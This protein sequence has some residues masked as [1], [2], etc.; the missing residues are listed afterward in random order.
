MG[1]ETPDPWKCWFLGEQLETKAMVKMQ[2]V[3]GS[4]KPRYSKTTTQQVE[5]RC[6]GLLGGWWWHG[7][8]GAGGRVDAP[9]SYGL[10]G[11]VLGESW[12]ALLVHLPLARLGLSVLLSIS[13]WALSSVV[14]NGSN[15][16]M[17]I[18][19][20]EGKFHT[21]T[22]LTG[23][24]FFLC[25]LPSWEMKGLW[26]RVGLHFSFLVFTR[27]EWLSKMIIT[28]LLVLVT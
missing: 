26:P 24:T 5:S 12:E 10:V 23:K 6:Q 9:R 7:C 1:W 17:P 22:H 3:L 28:S 20:L 18:A 21:S 11:G 14:L 4:G 8:R 25:S 2:Y 16:G 13:S 27:L 19:C 15:S